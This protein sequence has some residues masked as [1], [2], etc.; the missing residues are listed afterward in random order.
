[1]FNI[2]HLFLSCF[3]EVIC[4]FFL[5]RINVSSSHFSLNI[6]L[7]F[8]W[9][10]CYVHWHMV[11]LPEFFNKFQIICFQWS[12]YQIQ[13]KAFKTETWLLSRKMFSC[14]S[15]DVCANTL[16]GS[17]EKYHFF[18]RF[19]FVYNQIVDIQFIHLYTIS[20]LYTFIWMCIS[21]F[22]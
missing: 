18:F 1:M 10:L 5:C 21:G 2:T 16:I 19:V 11:H 14:V 12:K 9:A 4:C 13:L 17:G 8:Y 22:K 15:S 6:F 3:D 7:Y 20:T